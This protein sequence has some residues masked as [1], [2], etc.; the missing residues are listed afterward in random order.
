MVFR[1]T[2]LNIGLGGAKILYYYKH[3]EREEIKDI[4][5]YLKL[6]INPMDEIS[7]SRIA[8]KPP[9]GIG[10]KT[11]EVVIRSTVERGNPIFSLGNKNSIPKSRLTRVTDF[12]E[13]CAELNRMVALSDPMLL[14][15]L[16]FDASGYLE[17]LRRAGEEERIHNLEELY[18]AVEE[19]SKEHP[20]APISDF[21]EE[22][23]LSQGGIEGDGQADR[24]YLITLHNAKGLE[25]PAVFIAGMEDGIFPH[26]LSGDSVSDLQE[27]RRLCYVGMTRAM[28]RL[29]LS[30]AKVRKLYGRSVE[31]GLS[32]F[33]MELPSELV[34]HR[35]EGDSITPTSM[36]VDTGLRGRA[37]RPMPR[38]RQVPDLEV[39]DRVIHE[40]YGR[41]IVVEL[42]EGIASIQ[43]DDGNRMKFLLKYTPLKKDMRV[44]TS[45][46]EGG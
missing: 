44:G 3:H 23:T 34:D 41:G 28:E 27:E 8:N 14:L 12:I 18:N 29:Y 21:V 40:Q 13:L 2:G 32:K 15:K 33:L 9:R 39:E 25:F 35:E 17:W 10:I 42:E 37:P 19:F 6:A 24:V 46:R 11:V 31:R 30:A 22:V 7:F 43:F 26:Y 16:L 38:E 4:L 36:R 1:R 20:G 5:A 45:E